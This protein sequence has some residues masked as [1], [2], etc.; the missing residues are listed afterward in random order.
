[1][2]V[3]NNDYLSL[4][5]DIETKKEMSIWLDLVYL[6]KGISTIVAYL[7]PMS[8]LWKKQKCYFLIDSLKG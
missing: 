4:N 2:T 6:L 8:F 3:R 1:M 7:M 5:V